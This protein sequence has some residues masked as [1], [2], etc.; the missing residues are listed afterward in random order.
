[1]DIDESKI[2]DTKYFTEMTKIIGN[3]DVKQAF[4]EDMMKRY[5]SLDNWNEDIEVIMTTNIKTKII[6]GLPQFHKYM[7]EQYV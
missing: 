2:G 5:K 7:K 4:Y 3:H 1:L 6:E